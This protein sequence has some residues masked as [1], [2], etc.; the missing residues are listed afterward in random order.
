MNAEADL[1]AAE[2]WISHD[3]DPSDRAELQSLVDAAVAGDQSASQ[4]I[5]DR[6][7]A[8]LTFG[9][10]GLRGAMA[11]GPNRMNTAV[12][13]T[14]SAGLAAVL[15]EKV[16]PGFK[17]VVGFDGRHRSAD[18]AQ[19]AAGIFVAAGGEVQLMPTPLPTPLT[20]FAIRHLDADAA[21]MVTASH[22]PAADNGYKVY[23][24]GRMTDDAVRGIQ[25]VPPLDAEI[26]SAIRAAGWADEIA[27]AAEG[28][29]VLGD[30][31]VDAYLAAT[32]PIRDERLDLDELR[33]VLTAM[34][35]VGYAVCERLL[36][37]AGVGA[38]FPVEAQRQ[39]DPDF[40]TVNFPNPEEAG[41]LDLA[42]ETARQN[43]ADLVVALDPDADRC[44]VAIPAPEAAAGWRQLSGD[45][46]G[47]LLG[48]L[49]AQR[50][51][52]KAG[53]KRSL[54]RSIVSSSLLDSIAQRHGL[55]AEQTLTG[56]KWIARAAN[57]GYGYEEAI[58]YCVNPDAVKDKDGIST[59]LLA[60]Q[61]A[62]QA[63]SAGVS[64]QDR[65]DALAM[66]HG[67]HATAPLTFR[68]DDL[69]LISAGL[70]RLS[71]NPPSTLAGSQ[72]IE[73]ADLSAG[74]R[75]LPPTPGFRIET[76]AA[77]RVVVRPSGT[78]PK[79]KCYLEVVEQVTTTIELEAARIRT[80]ERLAEISTELREI[81]G[82]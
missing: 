51:E 82:F 33:V 79:L 5:A 40:P 47:G 52:S 3:P 56:F 74:W 68:V 1:S 15:H 69:A 12:V 44:A 2:L 76:A 80:A 14:A 22:N 73:F 53:P 7:A 45:E 9:T 58:G 11:A 61:L 78:E 71:A 21:V 43:A 30:D 65:L 38:I 60:V 67:L 23:V 26:E 63:K 81:L 20:A 4:Q 19:T 59:A 28:W 25:I 41:A 55:L 72:V 54:A 29:T 42:F 57:I 36:R 50:L 48:E 70:E 75:G 35:G 34:H 24:G 39:P 66:T 27:V 49:M 6:M 10:A 62:A 37:Q 18:F 31:I 13:T 8:P 17:V 77:D 46:L 16:G 32:M 64:I